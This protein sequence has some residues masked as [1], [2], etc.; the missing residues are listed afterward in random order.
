MKSLL[1]FLISAGV[2]SSQLLFTPGSEYVYTYSGKILSGIPELDS[3]FAGISLSGQ[4]ILQATSQSTFKLAMKEV[5]FSQFN[6]N[7]SGLKPFNW[8]NVVT[9]ATSPV[10]GM[11]KQYMESPVDFSITSDGLTSVKV[12]SAEPEWSINFKKALITALKIQLPVQQAQEVPSFW[13]AMEEGIDGKCE[14]TY[15]VTPLPAYLVKE[16]QEVVINPTLCQGKKFFEIEKA[17]DITKC[18]ERS[19]F[20]SSKAHKKCLLG[21]CDSVNTKSSVTKYF[22]CGESIKT[23]Q[24]HGIINEGELQ[25]N[26]FAFNTEPVVTGTKQT[27]KLAA[28][29]P[30]STTIPSIQSPVT[31]KDLL[32]VFPNPT[33]KVLE[34]HQQFQQHYQQLRKNP[35]IQTFLP[36]GSVDKISREEIKRKVVEKLAFVS[37]QLTDIEQFGKKEIPSQ[38]KSLK[39]V[40]SILTTEDLKELYTI[41][42]AYPA[43]K[44]TKETMRTL[45]LETVRMAGTSPC[46]VFIK[47]MIDTQEFSDIEAFL[48]ITTLPHNIKTPTIELIDQ[49]FE[50]IKSPVIKKNE[51]L[52]IH[53]HL[54]FATIVQKSC[55]AAPV[56]AV[57]PEHIF[58]EMCSPDHSKVTQDYI[59][60]FVKELKATAPGG[61]H[62]SGALSVLAILGHESLIPVVI[63]YIEGKAHGVSLGGR[64]MAIYSL[65][66]VAMKY[67]NTLMPIF[68]S[69]FHNPSEERGVRIAAFSMMMRMKPSTT[70]LQKLAVSTWYEQ[71]T[72]VHKFIHSSLK[73]LAYID[74]ANHPRDS[75]WEDLTIKAQ[76]VLP[77][78][79]PVP[80]IISSTFNSYISDVLKNLH[81]GSQL[82]TG[83]I[84]QPS[85]YLVYHRTEQ[86]MKQLQTIPM[87]FAVDVRG[88]KALTGELMKT[89]TGQSENYMNNIHSEWKNIIQS[90]DISS[91]TDTPFEFDFWAKFSDDIQIIIGAN[92]KIVDMIKE[93][94]EQ[95]I[96]N[97]ATLMGK[98]CGQT[99][100][101]INKVFEFLPYQAVV[102]SDLGLPIIVETQLTSL[103][104]LKGSVDVVCEK[105]SFTINV[106]KKAAYTYNGY[107]GT[108]S[109]FTQELVAAGINAH[110]AVNIPLKGKLEV[111]PNTHTLKIVMQQV[112]AISP[113]TTA[114]DLH[115]YHVKPFTTMKP[116]V[117]VDLTP[118]VLHKNTKIINSRA[119]PKI[120]QLPLGKFVG[121]NMAW[122]VETQCDI[123]DR[124]THIDS[125]ANYKFNPFMAGLFYFTETAIN[126][127]GKPSAR[128]HMYTI[129]HNPSASSTK[130]AEITLTLDFAT[131]KK[132]QQPKKIQW[133]QSQIQSTVLSA[134][135][136]QEKSLEYSIKKLKAEQVVAVHALV[137]ASLI[138]D[139]S[140]TYSYSLTVGVGSNI[141]EHK[142]NLHLETQDGGSPVKMCVDGSM[143]YPVASDI[144]LKYL[145]KIGFGTTCEQYT[146]NIDGIATVSHKQQ[147]YS[148]QSEEA[149]KCSLLKSQCKKLIQQLKSTVDQ[150]QKTQLEQQYSEAAVQ[151]DQ[152]CSSKKQQSV[153]LDQ[154]VVAIATSNELPEIISTYG[155]MINTGFKGLLLPYMSRIPAHQPQHKI[156]IKAN[157]NQKINTVTMKVESS[158]ESVIY[159]NIRL[160]SALKH[161]L[162]L[163]SVQHPVEQI[164]QGLTGS[165]LYPTCSLGQGYIQTYDQKSYAYQVDQCDHVLSADCSGQLSHSVL[166]KEVSGLKYVTIYSGKTKIV[167]KPADSYSPYSQSYVMEFDGENIPVDKSSPHFF[168][169]DE[170][171]L[172]QYV[173]YW[174][175]FQ[176]A[177]VLHTPHNKVIYSSKMV[178]VQEKT[179]LGDGNMCGLCGDANQDMRGDLSSPKQCVYSTYSLSALSYRVRNSQCSISSAKQQQ[180][181][182]E[183]SVCAKKKIMS[184]PLQSLVSQQGSSSMMKHS[185]TYQQGKICISQQ[186]VVQCSSGYSPTA[187][188]SK[189]VKFVCLP[190]G[191]VS[192]LYAERIERGESPQ[193]LK[194]QPIAWEALMAQPVGCGP[195]V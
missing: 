46:I 25:Q 6:E 37:S 118:I 87:E 98:L 96:K 13:V 128:P 91:R 29:K 53:A 69:L 177:V 11:A 72:E 181:Q 2:V 184:S 125:W 103:M 26:V 167:L 166:V 111:V 36:E 172:S 33:E 85:G 117:F 114:V 176:E 9:P 108:V 135:S 71:D 161:I 129:S 116:L 44:E 163:S 4:V 60:Y 138:G 190:E 101:N 59:P 61:M 70:H 48:A 189:S 175:P 90:L 146:I 86:F 102:P 20:M 77:L 165:S 97:P 49:V 147:E 126:S 124:K 119:T 17:R 15:Q 120:F 145:N 80:G 31:L 136:D 76:T 45:L 40:I 127:A 106:S 174:C 132:Q 24:L 94:I 162:P 47:E 95:A 50:L 43:Q 178:K 123:L 23:I 83:F 67:R 168:V 105:P 5:G 170:S 12:S 195:K 141:M 35:S 183:E 156:V 64:K 171:I 54:V 155:N 7:F 10:V 63:E 115:H 34:S 51:L 153:A 58:G 42:K 16:Y 21:N 113:S 104:S 152:V 30:L 159:E 18:M 160:P 144:T 154:V 137:K 39:T 81:V 107:V 19:I 93:K 186:P 3:T 187:V 149:Q 130:Q 133:S 100:I 151:K 173:A 110:R 169:K 191:R 78:A 68:A 27:L 65:A 193:E 22:G 28:V 194:H 131:M 8:R 140:K 82:F 41:V 179:L 134:R 74:L 139:Q 89:L 143:K 79:K 73:T 14:N 188:T 142:W 62:Q 56:S 109:P 57:F 121:L 164:S 148:S 55:L 185:Y 75:L 88:L 38:M 182:A 32:Y 1:L 157:F 150:Q 122:N 84:T 158:A 180:I 92:T 99:P 52:K 192:K 112:D 66:D